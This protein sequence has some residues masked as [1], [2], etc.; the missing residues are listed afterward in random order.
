M[1]VQFTVWGIPAPQGSKSPWGTESNPNTRPWRAAVAAEAAIAMKDHMTLV[2]PIHLDVVFEF[3]RPKGH[4]GT[5]KNAHALK[6]SA[7]RFHTS[8]PD[9][10]KLARAIGD[11]LT[12]IVFRDD[13]QISRLTVAKLYNERAGASIFVQELGG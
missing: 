2:G 12:G 4:Y 6:G 8:K 5:G 10:D 11:A 3:T 1:S 7:P 13:S 9:V